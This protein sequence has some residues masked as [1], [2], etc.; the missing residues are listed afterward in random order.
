MANVP[1][2]P[3]NHVVSETF[4]SATVLLAIPLL[5]YSTDL[6]GWLK[7]AR[8]SMLSFV[9]CVLSGMTASILAGWWFQDQIQDYWILSGMLVGIYTGGTANVNA[10]GLA[11]GSSQELLVLI[12][13]ADIFCGGIYLIFLTSIAH[14][15]FSRFLPPFPKNMLTSEAVIEP[16]QQSLNWRGAGQA[17]LLTMVLIGL[18]LGLTKLF[19]GEL[20]NLALII[21]LLTT[22]SIIASL[23]AA[24]RQINGT[25]EMGEYLLLMFSIAIGMEADFGQIW[26]AGGTVILF[27]AI[28][29]FSTVLLHLL[30]ARLFKI[31]VDTFMITSTAALYSPVFIGQIASTI[32]NRTLVFSGIAT[33]LVGFAL[34]NYLGIGIAYWVKWLVGG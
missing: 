2:L 18:T 17:I 3:L 4:V 25:F 33:G 27:T 9:L 24:V 29:L 15:V 7:Y 13:A 6:R 31:D 16:K 22:L 30:F 11:L 32:K 28:V 5:L 8:S 1:L 20:Q 10:I 21:L 34:G 19:T 26:G 12:N 23:F 14:R